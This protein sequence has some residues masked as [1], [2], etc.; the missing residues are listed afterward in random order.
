[1]GGSL[2]LKGIAAYLSTGVARVSHEQLKEACLHYDAFDPAN[3]ATHMKDFAAEASGT[4]ESGYTLTAR[5]L[6][7]ATEII[8]SIVK[9]PANAK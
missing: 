4:K 8:K 3:F 7:A 1:L 5:G 9:A 6:T 2:L